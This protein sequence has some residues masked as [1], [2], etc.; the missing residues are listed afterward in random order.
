MPDDATKATHGAQRELFKQCMLAVQ[1]GMEGNPWR[2]G[3]PSPG[4]SRAI[5]CERTVKP[6]AGSGNAPTPPSIRLCWWA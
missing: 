5:Y 6:T 1:Y 3:Q 2:Y 4:S